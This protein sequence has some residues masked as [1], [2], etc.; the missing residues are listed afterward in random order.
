[1]DNKT[2]D[3]DKAYKEIYK[4]IR[5]TMVFDKFLNQFLLKGG[6]YEYLSQI[7]KTDDEFKIMCEAITT[8]VDMLHEI[9]NTVN[10]DKE[11]EFYEAIN[12]ALAFL[13]VPDVKKVVYKKMIDTLIGDPNR[14]EDYTITDRLFQVLEATFGLDTLIM[15]CYTNDAIHYRF[16][17]VFSLDNDEFTNFL[18]TF[19]HVKN[20][21]E[22]AKTDEE[23]SSMFNDKKML[24]R[25][26]IINGI[27]RQI[28]EMDIENVDDEK[29][30]KL[31]TLGK[32]L[33]VK[34]FKKM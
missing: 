8:Y 5:S 25:D 26:Y 30:E 14:K 18:A 15:S 24:F 6:L 32:E 20:E 1:M 23:L 3:L 12:D 27:E 13:D 31:V 29:I 34:N 17:E 22:E 16:C 11:N 2:V 33:D 28:E 4:Q 19:S 10:P 9:W 7:C 21:L